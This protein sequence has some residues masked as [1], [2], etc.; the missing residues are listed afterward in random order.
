MLA[1][2]LPPRSCHRLQPKL[3]PGGGSVL[4]ASSQLQGNPAVL[5]TP[6]AL[7]SAAFLPLLCFLDHD[8]TPKE[9]RAE[10]KEAP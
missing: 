8:P 9:K 10:A 7:R 6:S 4:L 5:L 1:D 2:L 3:M